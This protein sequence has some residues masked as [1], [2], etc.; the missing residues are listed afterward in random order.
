MLTTVPTTYSPVQAAQD[1]RLIERAIRYLAAQRAAQPSLEDVAAHVGLSEYHFQRLF[2]RWAGI[3]PKRFLQFLTVDHARGVLAHSAGLLET[4]FDSG[5]SGPSRLHDLFIAAE[6]VTPGEYRR[7]GSGLR[8]EYAFHPSPF[9]D[10]LVAQTGRGICMLAFAG[11][12]GQE[13]A[14]QELHDRWGG[15]EL[16][17]D[18][19]AT[20]SA[21]RQALGFAGGLSAGERQPLYLHL[22]GTNFQLKVW[23]ALLRI[24]PGQALTYAQVAQA[25]GRPSAARAVGAAVGANP[26][27]W[28]IPCHRVIRAL[29]SFGG[30]LYGNYRW[31]PARKAAL[32]GWEAGRWPQE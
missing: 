13:H 4:A 15:A 9:G 30:D 6:A 10:M 21:A 25:I 2:S 27:A 26:V 29:P 3:S 5:L 20:R 11:E 17:A 8:I 14:R 24:P 31:G 18:E 19:P 22:R 28:L 16:V 12:E 7:R 32:L 23:E 1:Y